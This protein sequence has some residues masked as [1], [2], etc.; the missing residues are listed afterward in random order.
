MIS[1]EQ[2]ASR[3][4]EI[5]EIFRVLKPRQG[6]ISVTDAKVPDWL[7][8]CAR[9]LG[10]QALPALGDSRLPEYPSSKSARIDRILRRIQI[11]NKADDLER[12]HR[13]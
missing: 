8:S 7:T 9:S 2:L 5:A 6:A 1:D 3:E 10:P 12:Q 4:R 13:G 11:E